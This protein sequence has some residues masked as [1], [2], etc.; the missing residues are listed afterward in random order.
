M[1]IICVCTGNTCRSPMAA[2]LLQRLLPGAEV[3]SAG[4][5]A[6]EGMPASR[7]ALLAMDEMGLDISATAPAVSARKWP[8]GR[9]CWP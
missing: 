1:K 7:H 4:L 9:C 5:Y 2:A 6:E 3:S 8:K